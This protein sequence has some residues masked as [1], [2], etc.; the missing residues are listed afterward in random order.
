MAEI[1]WAFKTVMSHYLYNS[2]S[3]LES[4]F[5]VMFPDSEI[6][7]QISLSSSKMSCLICHGVAPYFRRELVSCLEKCDILVVSFDEAFN[8]VSKKGQMDLLSRYWDE[9]TNRVAVRYLNS[10]FM[11]HA[12]SE[13]IL[14]LFKSALN[15]IDIGKIIEISMDGP[16]VNWKFLELY[17]NELREIYQKTLQTLVVVGSCLT[18]IFSNW[19]F[20]SRMKYKFITKKYV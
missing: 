16:S 15:P 12:T 8:E 6:C 18:L 3:N 9:N 11:R 13:D 19:P 7:K 4:L 20:C 10:A 2:S 17:N 5:K 14:E 1:R